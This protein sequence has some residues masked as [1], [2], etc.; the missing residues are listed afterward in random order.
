MHDRVRECRHFFGVKVSDHLRPRIGTERDKLRSF[1]RELITE[2]II[3]IRIIYGPPALRVSV[4][5]GV[6]IISD[7]QICVFA[8]F[9]IVGRFIKGRKS[10]SQKI[11]RLRLQFIDQKVSK[12]T[13]VFIAE[14]I[15]GFLIA[16]KIDE[17]PID[18]SLRFVFLRL[19]GRRLLRFLAAIF[20]Q[21]SDFLFRDRILCDIRGRRGGAAPALFCKKLLEIC[22]QNIGDLRLLF[23]YREDL[24]IAEQLEKIFFEP[25]GASASI[26]V[27]LKRILL[28]N[29]KGKYRKI[30][31]VSREA[32][33]GKKILIDPKNGDL[34]GHILRSRYNCRVVEKRA[35][36]RGGNITDH[37]TADSLYVAAPARVVFNP[38]LRFRSGSL[39]VGSRCSLCALR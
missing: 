14:S 19:F 35:G 31:A 28:G 21:R 29:H 34:P 37:D 3:R 26:R 32:D 15:L 23:I 36:H 4:C 11:D 25:D 24:R 22:R 27:I 39:R 30:G 6:F 12:E 16:V 7:H 13:E 20:C 8:Q 2:L 18:F 38:D 1:D 5:P 10:L 33:I 17:M 9:I